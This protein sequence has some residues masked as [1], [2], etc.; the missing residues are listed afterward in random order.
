MSQADATQKVVDFTKAQF[1]AIVSDLH[2]C[3]EEPA[4]PKYPL[5][6]KYKTRQ[7]FFDEEFATFLKHI[8]KMAQDEPTELILNG[9][10]FDFDSCTQLPEDPTYYISWLERRRGLHPQ[11]EKSVFKIETILRDHSVW[12]AALRDF[13][14]KG[15]RVVFTIGNHDLELHFP[16]VQKAILLALYLPQE[17]QQQVRFNEWFY[18]SNGDTLVEHGNQYDPYCMFQDPVN[19]YILKHNRYEIR[20]PFGNL[21]TRYLINGMGFFNP[22]LDANYIMSPKQYVEF[23]FKYMARAQ[24]LLMISWLWG[25]TAALFQSFF[26]RLRP[27]INDPLTIEDRIDEIALKANATPRMVRELKELFV[28][29]A[30]SYPSIIA[31]ELWLDRAFLILALLITLYVVFL[32]IDS[33]Y[34]IAIWWA[35]VPFFLFIPFFLFYSRSIQSTVQEFKEPRE[36][37]LSTAG[38]ITK[39][40]RIVYGHTHVVRHEVIG[41]IEHLNSGTWSPAF[42]DVECEKPVGQKTFV[43]IY[44]GDA[45]RDAKVYQIK[46]GVISEVFAA[47]GG[48]ADRQ[49]LEETARRWADSFKST[50]SSFGRDEA[51]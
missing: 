39:V 8:M 45:G 18:I 27:T 41:A 33:V 20:V 22:H 2:L 35:L 11:E 12:V 25:S 23:F 6:K 9:D 24:P 7:F 37:T 42:M 50:K 10:I 3:E 15:N 19:P 40:S 44:P 36:K 21:T 34:N 43:W 14:L 32:Q 38:L 51:G 30:A 31:K 13:V 16:G 4:H 47:A 28:P 26:D 17:K 49:K 48:K 5:W 46:S 1:T 29:P